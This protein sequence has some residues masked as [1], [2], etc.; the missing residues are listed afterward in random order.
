MHNMITRSARIAGAAV[1]LG[2]LAFAGAHAADWEE[3]DSES[4][5]QNESA[6][7]T[8]SEN[9]AAPAQ[10]ESVGIAA[11][12]ERLGMAGP[13][14]EC[15]EDVL[16]EKLSPEEQQQAAD[17][18]A[19]ASDAEEVRISVLDAGETIVGG[20]SAADVSCPEGFGE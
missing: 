3:L 5:E 2:S 14:A 10:E 19:D 18:I 16:S 8:P 1:L 4:W 9:G 15:Y 12:F 17:L 13:R 20:F 7:Q 6:S 11:A